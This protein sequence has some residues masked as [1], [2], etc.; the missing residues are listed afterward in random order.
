MMQAKNITGS[1]ILP[2]LR[3]PTASG[4]RSGSTWTAQRFPRRRV[5]PTFCALPPRSG[6]KN[7]HPEYVN[8]T[9]GWMKI[10]LHWNR[11]ALHTCLSTEGLLSFLTERFPSTLKFALPWDDFKTAH[12]Q[13]NRTINDHN[14][15]KTCRQ[16]RQQKKHFFFTW[17]TL[18]QLF[19]VFL[20]PLCQSWR[21]FIKGDNTC[22]L[23]CQL[24]SAC[25]LVNGLDILG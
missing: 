6:L 16:K 12:Q 18:L 23:Q 22:I 10:L 14:S 9:Q 3:Q 11:V 21:Q 19:K 15:I 8:S 4:S 20:S 17:H 13:G 5:L 2:V 7:M 25:I 1:S 24:D